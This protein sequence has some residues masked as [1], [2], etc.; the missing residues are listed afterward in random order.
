[1]RSNKCSWIR[2]CFHWLNFV[3]IGPTDF[4]DYILCQAV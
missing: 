1:M 2:E 4:V 3:Q